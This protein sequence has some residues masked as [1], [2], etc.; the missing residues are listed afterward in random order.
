MLSGECQ[1]IGRL[2][3]DRDQSNGNA[4]VS[5][6]AVLEESLRSAVSERVGA[7]RFAL[8]FGGNVRL[9]LNREGDLLIVGVPD[10]FF[11][12]WI[13]RH[14]APTLAEAVE[15]VVGRKLGVSVQVQS[16][17]G[18]PVGETAGAPPIDGISLPLQ[19]NRNHRRRFPQT[20]MVRR[21]S[22]RRGLAAS[23]NAINRDRIVPPR[24]QMADQ[25]RRNCQSGHCADS[26]TM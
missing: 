24:P 22:H 4:E 2:D 1:L 11:R 13:E 20:R 17:S 25:L 26:K 8:W 21:L 6:P 19:E 14:Y 10:P 7:T 23:F 5:G 18:P 16:E 3:E 15:A 9:G 12:D